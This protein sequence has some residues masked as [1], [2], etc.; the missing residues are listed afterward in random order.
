MIVIL[1]NGLS[2]LTIELIGIEGTTIIPGQTKFLSSY[3]PPAR[4]LSAAWWRFSFFRASSVITGSFTERSLVE[5]LTGRRVSLLF[6]QSREL[7]TNN[8]PRS[9]SI[10]RHLNAHTSQRRKPQVVARIIGRKTLVFSAMV[11]ILKQ[12][13]V[14]IQVWQ[15]A[16]DV[17]A[18]GRP[19][20]CG[21]AMVNI[22]MEYS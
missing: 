1:F 3:M 15:S 6:S 8:S 5:V 16:D 13:Q 2:K 17:P 9:K 10:S 20:L 12:M 21:R 4:I 7:R 14:S 11:M 19:A 18:G 22:S